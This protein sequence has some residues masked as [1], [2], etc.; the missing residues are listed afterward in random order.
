MQCGDLKFNK[1]LTDQKRGVSC[2]DLRFKH[3]NLK[4]IYLIF[5]KMQ[6]RQTP[7]KNDLPY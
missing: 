4:C 3:F 5:T 1:N 6:K 7:V 2:Q